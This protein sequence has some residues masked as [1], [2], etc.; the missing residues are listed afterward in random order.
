MSPKA[1]DYSW[2]GQGEKENRQRRVKRRRG[3]DNR[4]ELAG[5]RREECRS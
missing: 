5:E 1:R 2:A 3:G 4:G